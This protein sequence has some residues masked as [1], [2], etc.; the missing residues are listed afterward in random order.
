M[1]TYVEIE[2]D[3]DNKRSSH[4]YNF[5]MAMIYMIFLFWAII[6]AMKVQN[7][8]N[9]ILHMIFALLASPVY[10]LSYYLSQY[11]D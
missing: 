2:D 11:K 3:Y 1:P 10:I 4:L 7:N 6:L 5:L 9:K 8:E